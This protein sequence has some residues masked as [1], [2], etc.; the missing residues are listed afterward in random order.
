M[1]LIRK[2]RGGGVKLVGSLERP[3]QIFM[4]SGGSEMIDGCRNG[5]KFF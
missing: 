1:V 3:F 5:S 2:K 4:N